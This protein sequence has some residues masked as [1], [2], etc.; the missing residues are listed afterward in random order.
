M[1][2][3]FCHKALGGRNVYHTHPTVRE[4][5]LLNHETLRLLQMAFESTPTSLR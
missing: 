5:D 4:P 1:H 3:V 2:W